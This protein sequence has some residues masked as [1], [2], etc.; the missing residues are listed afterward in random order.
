MISTC[1]ENEYRD[2]DGIGM[3]GGLCMVLVEFTFVAVMEY[4][5]V[6]CRCN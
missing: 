4:D 1:N 5:E 6:R 2:C 3:V